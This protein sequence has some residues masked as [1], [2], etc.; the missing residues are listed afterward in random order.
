MAI[1]ISFTG[2][3]GTGKTTILNALREDPDFKDFEFVTEV[4]RKFVKELEMKINKEGTIETQKIIFQAYNSLLDR[5]GSFLSD[6]CILDV[7]S[8]TL[9]GLM[10]LPLGTTERSNFANCLCSQIQTLRDRRDD[11]GIIFYFPIEFPIESDSVR[12][13]DIDY[14]KEIDGSIRDLLEREEV[15]YITVSGSVE[16][17]IKIIKATLSEIS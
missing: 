9:A 5:E 17:R 11:L 15:P 12:S 10:A 16:E 4:V 8:Y 3:Q 14:Q 6:R 2:A 13:T 7:I 1:K